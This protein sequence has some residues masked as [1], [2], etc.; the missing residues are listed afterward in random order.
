MSLAVK[1]FD[2]HEQMKKQ[3]TERRKFNNIYEQMLKY[4][5]DKDALNNKHTKKSL[6]NYFKSLSNDKFIVIKTPIIL[7]VQLVY[8]LG[9]DGYFT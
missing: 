6:V 2:T 4:K 3:V 8:S 9:Y 7:S 5:I 1:M